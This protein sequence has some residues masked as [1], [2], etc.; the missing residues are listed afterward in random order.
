MQINE[1]Y[2]FTINKICDIGKEIFGDGP[3]NKSHRLA[4]HVP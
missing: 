2:E 1:K 4:S 3:V